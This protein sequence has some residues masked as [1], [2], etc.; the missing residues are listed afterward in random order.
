MKLFAMYDIKASFYLQP[1]PETSTVA[2]LRGFEVA[3]N[4][5]KSTFSRFPDDFALMELADFDQ[6]SGEII[7]HPAPLNLGTARTV[8][9]DSPH[10]STLPGMAQ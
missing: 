4:E 6:H 7:V 1:F 9:K 8:L 2:A 10:Q 3:V 5:G